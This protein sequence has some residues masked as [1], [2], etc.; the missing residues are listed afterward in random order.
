MLI[1]PSKPYIPSITTIIYPSRDTFISANTG[2]ESSNFGND[3]TLYISNNPTTPTNPG[4]PSGPG[5]VH[6]S[7]LYFDLSV[8][9][10]NATITSASL[11]LYL[12]RIETLNENAS[13][14]SISINQLDE[15]FYEYTATSA[16]CPKSSP[17]ISRDTTTLEINPTNNK[18][19]TFA[20]LTKTVTTWH[21]TESTNHGFEICSNC[22]TNSF[23]GFWSKEYPEADLHPTLKV[24]Y[25]IN[26]D[27]PTIE[28]S[29]SEQKIRPLEN[30]VKTLL[31]N[32]SNDLFFNYIVTNPCADVVTVSVLNF[33]SRSDEHF[34]I[35]DNDI[36]IPPNES[37]TIDVAPLNKYICLSVRGSHFV[38]NEKVTISSVS[39]SFSNMLPS[40]VSKLTR[41][42]D[43]SAIELAMTKP[44][45]GLTSDISLFNITTVNNPTPL[46]LSKITLSSS[47]V[48]LILDKLLDPKADDLLIITYT[49]SGN[50]GSYNLTGLNGDVDNFII[51]ESIK[52]P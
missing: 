46:L 44:L 50:P 31:Y 37:R 16:I 10:A 51:E 42:T 39:K 25:T 2:S 21:T 47:T 49:A 34:K 8:I 22:S 5:H 4:D 32:I 17:L 3:Y 7:F 29:V 24:E 28:A 38:E 11:S 19:I 13:N 12:F 52:T 36:I 20:N 1:D 33:E 27:I 23:L 14:P 26:S 41:L 35:S 15:D 45:T 48:T 9:P 43:G 6:K 40:K 18:F 30:G